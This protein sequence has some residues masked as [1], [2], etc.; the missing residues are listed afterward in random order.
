MP[1]PEFRSWRLPAAEYEQDPGTSVG[2]A[3]SLTMRLL[4]IAFG[5]ALAVLATAVLWLAHYA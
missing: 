2:L 5:V 1:L 3:C 4:F